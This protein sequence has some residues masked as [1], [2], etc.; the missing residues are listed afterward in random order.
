MDSTSICASC[1]LSTLGLIEKAHMPDKK[2]APERI[3][4]LC[5]LCHRAYD[6][7]MTTHEE[8]EHVEA[9]WKAG[10]QPPNELSALLITWSERPPNWKQLQKDAQMKAGLT[11]RRRNAGIKAA[12]TLA[13][14]KAKAAAAKAALADS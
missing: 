9:I 2:T 12:K 14:R 5:L 4:P 11:V 6:L 1:G 7:G 13:E 10:G 3:V 8:M